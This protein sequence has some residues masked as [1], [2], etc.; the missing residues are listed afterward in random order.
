MRKEN[1]TMNN[2]TRGYAKPAVQVMTRKIARN[3]VKQRVGN[4]RISVAWKYNKDSL[5]KPKKPNLLKRISNWAKK[6]RLVK[7]S[8]NSRRTNR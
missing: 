1:W 8:K 5:L 6:R 2:S 4:N 3:I 7:L